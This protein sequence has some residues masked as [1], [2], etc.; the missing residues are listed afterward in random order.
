MRKPFLPSQP[1]EIVLDV[2]DTFGCA[3]DYYLYMVKSELPPMAFARKLGQWLQ[4][5]FSFIQN[6]TFDTSG[7]DVSVPVFSASIRPQDN[8]MVAIVPNKVPTQLQN[9]ADSFT[10]SIPMFDDV[11]YFLN[12]EGFYRY[13]CPYNG[14]DFVLM[15]SVDKDSSIEQ[16][17][18]FLD[19]H[20]ELRT[21]DITS[22]LTPQE[23]PA[24]EKGK[25]KGKSKNKAVEK[26]PLDLFLKSC[27][28]EL[29]RSH[30]DA[31]YRRYG[32][33]LGEQKQIPDVNYARKFKNL[34]H[35]LNQETPNTLSSDTL[36][37]ESDAMQ[38]HIMRE[39]I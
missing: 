36:M 12:S 35:I 26:Q 2:N 33:F 7:P 20:K 11:Y 29:T 6:Y 30:D 27:C 31:I 8:L 25:K 15:I 18:Q 28:M 16:V 10:L 37:I 24:S 23:M 13:E 9:D 1:V 38:K 4:T 21:Q 3:T 17:L 14:Y 39:D 5:D 22:F 34:L 19:L 32:R